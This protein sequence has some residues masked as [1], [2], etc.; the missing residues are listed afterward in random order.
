MS[1][2]PKATSTDWTS[3]CECSYPGHLPP[4][5]PMSGI[6]SLLPE[7]L[8]FLKCPA[9]QSETRAASLTPYSACSVAKSPVN[10][11][12]IPPPHPHSITSL[13]SLFTVSHFSHT[14]VSPLPSIPAQ[15]PLFG[16][17]LVMGTLN[18]I[19]QPSL[20]SDLSLEHPTISQP[21]P[22]FSSRSFLRG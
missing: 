7:N 4:G 6:E 1:R 19:P 15:H 18:P 22:S 11:L 9:S 12:P 21:S 10:H 17:I 20:T 14:L 8:L 5:N 3:L 13:G 2:I 16:F